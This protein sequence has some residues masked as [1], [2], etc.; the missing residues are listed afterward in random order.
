MNLIT[1]KK[2]I[3]KLEVIFLIIKNHNNIFSDSNYYG[4]LKDEPSYVDCGVLAENLAEE[5]LPKT[6]ILTSSKIYYITNIQGNLINFSSD[7]IVDWYLCYY[8]PSKQIGCNIVNEDDETLK[9][10]LLYKFQKKSIQLKFSNHQ[11]AGCY[12]IVL[13]S[14]NLQVIE[15]SKFLGNDSVKSSR[16]KVNEF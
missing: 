5:I 3:E 15:M 13:T 12:F 16:V 1:S 11:Y 10:N 14:R 6:E 8:N 9:E 4:R 7:N 2:I